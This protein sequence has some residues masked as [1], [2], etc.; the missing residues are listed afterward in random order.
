[1]RVALIRPDVDIDK[2]ECVALDCLI[3]FTF[4]MHR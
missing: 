3:H 1:M 4:D 2:I